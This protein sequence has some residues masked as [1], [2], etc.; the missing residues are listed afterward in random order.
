LTRFGRFK[1][2]ELDH[3]KIVSGSTSKDQVLECG[4]CGEQYDPRHRFR[5]R[6]ASMH[7]KVKHTKCSPKEPA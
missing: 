3:I 6:F 2:G 1:P 7:W 5:R 4:R